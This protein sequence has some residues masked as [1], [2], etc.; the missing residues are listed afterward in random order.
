[1]II[2]IALRIYNELPRFGY[3]HSNLLEVL[4]HFICL[5]RNWNYVIIIIIIIIFY[6][7]RI[8]LEIRLV[9][10]DNK[11]FV[12]IDLL[13][14]RIWNGLLC[15]RLRW[16]GLWLWICIRLLLRLLARLWLWLWLIWILLLLLLG[17][18]FNAQK[19]KNIHFNSIKLNSV[20]LL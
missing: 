12:L 13:E 15:M 11:P 17:S 18:C 6:F 7:A 19:E 14:K 8:F 3:I 4:Y 16:A 2:I 10:F 1:M 5:T 9:F 20:F